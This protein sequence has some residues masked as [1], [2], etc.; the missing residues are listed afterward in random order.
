MLRARVNKTS[1]LSDCQ[2]PANTHKA[3]VV[4]KKK[5][6]KLDVDFSP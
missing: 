3:N 6:S 2:T 5:P 4:L 1:Q